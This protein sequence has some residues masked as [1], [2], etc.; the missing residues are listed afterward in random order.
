MQR[1]SL[2]WSW[3]IQLAECLPPMR[4]DA[5]QGREPGKDAPSG[6]EGPEP[7]ESS[8]PGQ[9]PSQPAEA[10]LRAWGLMGVCLWLGSS[11]EL[12]DFYPTKGLTG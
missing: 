10:D 8:G 3:F 5:E 1:V 6:R 12:S 2:S 11:L 7:E 4:V 9:C